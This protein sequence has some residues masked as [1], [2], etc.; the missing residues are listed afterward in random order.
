MFSA[1]SSHHGGLSDKLNVFVACA[2]VITMANSPNGLFNSM[3]SLWKSIDGVIDFFGFEAISSNPWGEPRLKTF[4]RLFGVVC[5]GI[6]SFTSET[7]QWN[8]EQASA[9]AAGRGGSRAS[10]KQ[11]IHY[12]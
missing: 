10:M 11:T 3:A 2:P 8:A 7:S 4:C 6:V 12:A 1:L 5:D 9:V